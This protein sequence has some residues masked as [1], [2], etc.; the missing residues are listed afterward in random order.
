[1]ICAR[2]ARKHAA[3]RPNSTGQSRFIAQNREMMHRPAHRDKAAMNGAQI[4]ESQVYLPGLMRGPP[5]WKLHLIIVG[6]SDPR[7]LLLLPGRR[8]ATGTNWPR[9]GMAPSA[10]P[11]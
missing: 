8:H 11:F 3:F 4:I 1:M 5:A 10:F 9:S 6:W 7:G 2:I